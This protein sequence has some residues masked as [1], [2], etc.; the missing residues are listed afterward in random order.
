MNNPKTSGNATKEGYS[1]KALQALSKGN[2]V[3]SRE[4]SLASYRK[5][6]A[7][8]KVPALNNATMYQNR[9][10]TE[11]NKYKR[12]EVARKNNTLEK[13]TSAISMKPSDHDYLQRIYD[14]FG[15]S[16]LTLRTLRESNRTKGWEKKYGKSYEKIYKDFL[17]DQGNVKMEMGEK[18]PFLTEV[19]TIANSVPTALQALP[20]LITNIVDPENPTAKKYEKLR[21]QKS[22]ENKYWRAGVKEHTGEKGDNVIDTINAVADRMANVTAGNA[23]A[24]GVGAVMAGLSE[25]NKQMDDLS[26]RDGV[27]GRKKALTALGHGAIEGAGTA[28]TQGILDKIPAVNG[29]WNNLLNVGKGAGNAAIENAVS[30]AAE[31]SLDTLINKENSQKKLNEELYKMQGMSDEDARDQANADQFNRVKNAAITGALFG[32]ATRGITEIKNGIMGVDPTRPK[33]DDPAIQDADA[34]ATE[35]VDEINAMKRELTGEPKAKNTAQSQ[36]GVSDQIAEEIKKDNFSPVTFTDKDG[37]TFVLSKSTRDG[38][39]WQLSQVS[40]TGEFIGHSAYPD[41]ASLL[42]ELK[43][44]DSVG[45]F[46]GLNTGETILDQPTITINDMLKNPDAYSLEDFDRA[47][48]TFDHNADTDGASKEDLIESLLANIEEEPGVGEVEVKIPKKLTKPIVNNTLSNPA[49]EEVT[50]LSKRYTTLKNSDLFQASEEKMKML[51]QA[52]EEGKFDKG[53]EG[54][55]Q[56]RDE[57]LKEYVDDPETA[58]AKNLGKQWDSGKD[59]DTSMLL[60]HDALDNGDQTEFNLVAL[61]QATEL[62]GAARQLRATRD[63]SGTKEGTLTKGVEFLNDKAD[64]VLGS[65]KVRLE[66]EDMTN[67]MFNDGDFS[68]LS[69]MG[70]DEKNIQNIQ[71]AIEAGASKNTITKMLAM[72]RAVGATGISDDTIQKITDIFNEIEARKL[73]P[74]SKARAELEV[75]AYK[76]LAQ[77]IGGKR[78]LK[79]MWDSWRYLAMLGNPKTHLRNLLGN[80]THYMVTEAKDNVA[81]LLEASIDKTNRAFG[82]EGI[83]RTKTFL[84]ADDNNLVA[85]A[86][87]DAD[88]V[89]YASLNDMG[90]KYNVK[91]EIERARNSF[92]NKALSRIDDLNSN[93]LDLE[94]YSA[95]KRKYSRSLARYLKA[96]GAGE[97]IFDATDDASKALLDDA[98]AYA[99]DQAKQATFHEYSKTAEKLTQFSKGL[100][101]GSATS[102]L[103]GM[104]IEGLVPFKKTPINILKQAIK[105]SPVSLAKAVGKTVDAIRTGNSSATDAI[106]ELASGLTGTGIMA[107]GYFLSRQGLLTG[108]ANEDYD[109]DNAESE[110]GRQNY[111]IKIGDK[112]YTL[113]WLAPFSLPLFV[114]AELNDLM[115][116]EDTDD[117]DAIDNFFGALSDIS[118]PITEMSMLQ[119]IQNALNELSYSRE[120]VMGT[121]ISNTAL[122]YAS[123]G[124]PTLSGQLARAVDPYRRSTYSDQPSG[125]K[126][127]FD[128]TI[129]KSVVNKIPFLSMAKGQPYVDYKGNPQKNQGLFGAMLG[130]DNFGTRL[131]DQMLSPGYY[132][133]GNKSDMDRELNRLYD[134]TGVDVYPN[135]GSGKIDGE[136]IDKENFTKYQ[137]QYGQTTDKFFDAAIN[138]SFYDSL[139]DTQ[140]SEMLTGLRDLSRKFAEHDVGG[141]EL[142]STDQKRYDLYKEKGVDGIIEYY[143]NKMKAD[144]LGLSISTYEKKQAEYPGGA[145]QYAADK[146]QADALGLTVDQ[147]NKKNES[148]EGGAEAFSQDKQTALDMGFVDDKGNADVESYNNAINIFGNDIP[149][150]EAY[151]EFQSH[152]YTK[153]AQ[154]I[155]ELINNNAFTPEEKGMMLRGTNPNDLGKIARGMYDMS[156]Y[157]GVYYY[158]LAKTLA[159]ADGNGYVKKAEKSNFLQNIGSYPQF[160]QLSQDMLDYLSGNLR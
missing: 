89:A 4:G 41:D 50:G 18:H 152:G 52:K 57:A 138:S 58:R 114:G 12:N 43:S 85:K 34:K 136:R 78:N 123:Q 159:D 151:K 87:Q 146:E 109:V 145:A 110:Q 99:I 19:G 125:F 111:A 126:R 53:T 160:N 96:N 119:G 91:D 38:E 149:K 77:D 49:P 51:E 22:E 61:K 121:L 94:D 55:M 2:Y 124:I 104:V 83:N 76:V 101:E 37:I 112:S 157:E 117:G 56:A 142:D 68:D 132:K 84:T 122:G 26:L 97:E 92:N 35:A 1:L 59:I 115:S 21:Q 79:D 54:R 150:L 30:E 128:K 156:G 155:P 23:V 28:I 108:G 8:N 60:M 44:G 133:E 100:Q 10:R 140:K 129:T 7:R 107:L 144:S 36:I 137:T 75:D 67:R 33:I 86:A 45:H 139:D 70:M 118:E 98:R 69:R 32:G 90:N 116:R 73:N 148:Y 6:Q 103:G 72:Y 106:E 130:G 24:P 20:S 105:Y 74:T 3:Q 113:D 127:Q 13:R 11:A 134:A 31:M 147:F 48:R 120:S 39:K 46:N 71:N 66:L 14:R 25:A 143:G 95:L 16:D 102:K 5:E 17:A 153:D 29:V 82:G 27:S 42:R 15:D 135:V 131:L 47:F 158:Y 62:K 81:A 64:A 40:D 9:L 154:K 63:Y 141:K 88:D 93:L 80:T 65:K